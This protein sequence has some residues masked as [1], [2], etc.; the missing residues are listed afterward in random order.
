[1]KGHHDTYYIYYITL[2]LPRLEG[3]AVHLVRYVFSLDLSSNPTLLKGGVVFVKGGVTKLV[4]RTNASMRKR[5]K[6]CWC[7]N[8]TEHGKD[9]FATEPGREKYTVTV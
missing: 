3:H 9:D 7:N 5:D 2:Y 1:M 6:L 8:R 4:V